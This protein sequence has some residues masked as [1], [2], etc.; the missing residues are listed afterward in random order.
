MYRLKFKLIKNVYINLSICSRCIWCYTSSYNLYFK[1][2]INIH[3][4]VCHYH[5]Q[6]VC[7]SFVEL[8]SKFANIFWIASIFNSNKTIIHMLKNIY[9]ILSGWLKQMK[10]TLTLW[11]IHIERN[12]TYIITLFWLDVTITSH[13]QSDAT[14]SWGHDIPLNA[15]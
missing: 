15:S 8:N 10:E 4:V 6:F 7:D 9:Y 1:Y 5:V 14:L 13:T 12:I 3:V 2:I 11:D